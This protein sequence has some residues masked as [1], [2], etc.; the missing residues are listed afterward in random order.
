MKET[1]VIKDVCAQVRVL[2]LSGRREDLPLTRLWIIQEYQL[3]VNTN[4]SGLYD[5]RANNMNYA[6]IHDCTHAHPHTEQVLVSTRYRFHQKFPS[7]D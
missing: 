1:A 3:L 4:V 6:I 5:R 2:E 7:K